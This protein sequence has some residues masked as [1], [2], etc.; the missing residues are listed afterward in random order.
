[1]KSKIISKKCILEGK[2]GYMV[3]QIFDGEEMGTQ[4]VSE[5]DYMAYSQECHVF[6]ELIES[7]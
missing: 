3:S 2:P 1:M 6:P 4:F 5:S 7:E